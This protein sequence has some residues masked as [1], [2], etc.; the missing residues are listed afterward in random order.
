MDDG[1]FPPPPPPPG[2]GGSPPGPPFPDGGGGVP[3]G[4]PIP[5]TDDNTPPGPPPPCVALCQECDT[6][7]GGDMDCLCAC[8]CNAV[9]VDGQVWVLGILGMALFAYGTLKPLSKVRE[10]KRTE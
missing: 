2:G 7:C 3:P 6:Q 10:Q 4:P 1:G 9:P 8:E 5:G